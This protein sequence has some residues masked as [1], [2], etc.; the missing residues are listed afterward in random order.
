MF[1]HQFR[2]GYFVPSPVP[3]DKGWP[4]QTAR[5]S[6]SFPSPPP[7]SAN[8]HAPASATAPMSSSV[9]TDCLL[10]GSYA[11]F[12]SVNSCSLFNNNYLQCV[13]KNQSE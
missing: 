3:A 8:T 10:S 4:A 1:V 5:R 6:G 12:S 7:A 13:Q 9:P 2:A 11:S